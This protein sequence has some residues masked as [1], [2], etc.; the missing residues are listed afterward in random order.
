MMRILMLRSLLWLAVFAGA[1]IGAVLVDAPARA[2]IVIGPIDP[3]GPIEPAEPPPPPFAAYLSVPRADGS[4]EEGR[5][6]LHPHF[7]EAGAN[8]L[9]FELAIRRE[10]DYSDRYR[11]PAERHRGARCPWWADEDDA[12]A[13]CA[14]ITFEDDWSHVRVTAHLPDADG[15][16]N[17]A[18]GAAEGIGP[19]TGTFCETTGGAAI[20]GSV[21]VISKADWKTAQGASADGDAAMPLRLVLTTGATEA[22]NIEVDAV[23][24]SARDT[25]IA[26]SNHRIHLQPDRGVQ[27]ELF[28]YKTDQ[29]HH[30]LPCTSAEM[31]AE[32]M[33]E[34]DPVVDDG[35]IVNIG[36]TI[37]NGPSGENG[38][39]H[40]VTGHTERRDHQRRFLDFDR[41]V[42]EW[43]GP[44][45][46]LHTRPL[47]ECHPHG[48]LAAGGEC[49]L[50]SEDWFD[51]Y[52]L[53]SYS[54]AFA[55]DDSVGHLAVAFA[56][57]P[58]ETPTDHE[59]TAKL[60]RQP[61]PDDGVVTETPETASITIEGA[62]APSRPTI[63]RITD[64]IGNEVDLLI[65]SP[66]RFDW[67]L[68][69]YDIETVYAGPALFEELAAE[70]T[71]LTVSTDR[72]TFRMWGRRCEPSNS[73]CSLSFTREEMKRGYDSN[74]EPGQA[75]IPTGAASDVHR[76]PL[77]AKL[78]YF[79]P[80]DEPGPAVI[81][82]TLR[83][84]QGAAHG[85]EHVHPYRN[86][87]G[88]RFEVRTPQDVDGIL[89]PGQ[90]TEVHVGFAFTTSGSPGS[91]PALGTDLSVE[92]D[93]EHESHFCDLVNES[94]LDPDGSW[95][96]LG[97]GARWASP[98]W[99]SRLTAAAGDFKCA[100][101]EEASGAGLTAYFCAYGTG[102]GTAADPR[103]HPEL[104]VDFGTEGEVQLTASLKGLQGRRILLDDW[105]HR[106][107]HR[108][109]HQGD[110]E[111]FTTAT[112]R[113]G[114]V[115]QVV[116][117]ELRRAN[118]ESGPIR[119]G[120]TA[121]LELEVLSESGFASRIDA[122]SSI[123]VTAAGGGL[124]GP[125]CTGATERGDASAACS[126]SPLGSIAAAAK[127]DPQLPGKI[128]IRFAAPDAEG[129]AEVTASV[130]PANWGLP[131]NPD[132]LTIE[133]TGN[134]AKLS[135]GAGV[136]RVHRIGTP[137][138]GEERDDRDVIE[139]AAD[140]VDSMGR[141][142]ALPEV[143]RMEIRG[144]D[145]EAAG[146]GIIQTVDCR[147][148]G[149]GENRSR[150]RFVLDVEAPAEQPLAT[151]LYSFTAR[152]GD[153]VTAEAS[154]G[155][156]GPAASISAS[157]GEIPEVGGTL[158]VEIT[159]LDA[160]GQPVADGTEV[161]ITAE[162]PAAG[163]AGSLQA[164]S[165]ADGIARTANGKATASFVTT[166][167]GLSILRLQA[168]GKGAEPD[169]TAAMI[170]DTRRESAVRQPAELLAM[171]GDIAAGGFAGWRGRGPI[172]AS[173]LLADLPEA[174][175]L[176][177]WNGRRWL[178][179][180]AGTPGSTELLIA[181]GDVLW[182]G[183]AGR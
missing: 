109:W 25:A 27:P 51:S 1:A 11:T 165:P 154:F 92:C 88:L 177:L 122:I 91:N 169:A 26:G 144:P 182:I 180:R 137:D 56:V 118:E 9:E 14:G 173:E 116:S 50:A 68:F 153:T 132:P 102:Q 21:C 86:T 87:S 37:T 46:I 72:G 145:G 23:V 126:I 103:R 18:F 99:G 52:A 33:G 8:A 53:G 7:Y 157:A 108:R 141:T 115:E 101:D 22:R 131:L 63:Y 57:L 5:P 58:T 179:Y 59:I 30:Y 29:R 17:V 69:G 31:A 67:L 110:S 6:F 54:F 55:H 16:F 114:T 70:G 138:E 3:F 152:A 73:G 123:T 128:P 77:R 79:A 147:V 112:L 140:A 48:T 139:L 12:G 15:D 133:F 136:P 24:W 146:E 134:A 143:V 181:P 161:R 167:E 120:G 94:V 66:R 45:V 162:G 156:S 113:T 160:E 100:E 121:A 10:Y 2:Q 93:E 78:Y 20:P 178:A 119:K 4:A 64:E 13:A 155:V 40:A 39:D 130:A 81:S 61:V 74:R 158:E 168:G 95:F 42:F 80:F 166:W 34:C 150:C 151:G 127:A 159:V 82:A 142:T 135:L 60:Y 65:G 148:L 149:A 175:A 90:T 129:A 104:T 41:I 105:Y 44:A 76:V 117:A 84:A 32:D 83:D 111:Y 183:G 47:S 43:D 164:S 97:P 124:Y 172:A 36:L 176:W 19:K 106:G 49:T 89:E 38:I 71:A 107:V 35:E 62:T 171:R 96:A 85:R 125:Y 75:A 98:A 174:E 28:F 163:E 170:I